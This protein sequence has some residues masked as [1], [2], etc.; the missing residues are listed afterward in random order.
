MSKFRKN[1]ISV[2]ASPYII[3]TLTR[4]K[5]ISNNFH[6][7][8][9]TEIKPLVFRNKSAAHFL[10]LVQATILNISFYHCILKA[11]EKFG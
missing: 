11:P 3:I 5:Q 6:L 10:S 7:A 2:E 1:I 4:L 9:P 8:F